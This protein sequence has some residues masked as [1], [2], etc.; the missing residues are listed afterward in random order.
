MV[1]GIVSELS[2]HHVQLVPAG[3]QHDLISLFQPDDLRAFANRHLKRRKHFHPA[4]E[5][6]FGDFCGFPCLHRERS[7]N[8][9]LAALQVE[10]VRPGSEIIHSQRRDPA[11]LAIEHDLCAGRLRRQL[12]PSCRRGLVGCGRTRHRVGSGDDRIKRRDRRPRLCRA[13]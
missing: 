4:A 12:E 10:G 13:R 1:D 9:A 11:R 5:D 6:R 3:G 2:V 7:V 8:R